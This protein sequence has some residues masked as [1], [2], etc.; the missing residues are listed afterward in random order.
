[1]EGEGYQNEIRDTGGPG[2]MRRE[3]SNRVLAGRWRVAIGG[4]TQD[5]EKN[6]YYIKCK[7]ND[8]RTAWRLPG[9]EYN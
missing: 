1:M 2:R 5:I 9:A 7:V 3:L 6:K 8:L 4:G